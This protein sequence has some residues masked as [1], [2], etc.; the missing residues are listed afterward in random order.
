MMPAR[1]AV[2]TVRRD[3]M[4][5]WLEI[6]FI[7]W[8][9]EHYIELKETSDAILTLITCLLPPLTIPQWDLTQSVFHKYKM[10]FHL[11]KMLPIYHCDM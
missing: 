9:S 7:Y 2:M 8:W 1:V 6:V 10:L 5:Y 4:I 11:I 3:F